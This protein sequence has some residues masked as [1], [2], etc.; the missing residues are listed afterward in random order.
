MRPVAV[1]APTDVIDHAVHRGRPSRIRRGVGLAAA[2]A[3][4][5]LT[6]AGVT[7]GAS[8]IGGLVSAPVRLLSGDESLQDVITQ[9]LIDQ[10]QMQVAFAGYDKVSPPDLL[11]THE[12]AQNA[13][14]T[15]LGA[16]LLQFNYEDLHNVA[17]PFAPYPWD[18]AATNMQ[19]L[20]VYA[21]PDDQYTALPLT[22][23]NTYTMTITPP[24]GPN[25]TSDVTFLEASGNGV[26]QPYGTINSY[27]LDQFTPNANGS[28]TITFA[29]TNPDPG[30]PDFN[31]IE[32]PADAQRT[33]VRD[34][35]GNWGLP[36]DSFS[37]T[38]QGV[39]APSP[40]HPPLLTDSEISQ[41]ILGPVAEHAVSEVGSSDYFGQIYYTNLPEPNTMTPIGPTPKVIPAGPLLN[42]GQQY[43]S[44]GDFKL[45]P[46]EA[47]IL[48][49]PDVEGAY[50]SAMV[51]NI[52][53]QTAPTATATGSLNPGDTFHAPDGYTY[54][55]ISSQ[56][57]TNGTGDIY[58]NWLN[59]NGAADGGI[60]LRFQGITTPPSEPLQVQTYVVPLNDVGTIV[61]TDTPTITPAQYAA[62]AQLRL[63]E[64][65]YVHDQN[66]NTG[67]L[68][69]NLEY[70]QIKAA[71]GPQVFGQIF[72]GQGTQFGAPQEV[73]SVLDR[74]I[75]PALIPNPIT[76][77]ED[78]VKDPTGSVLALKDNLPLALNDIE[79]PT[80][81]SFLRLEVA[82]EQ[83]LGEL[84]SSVSSGQWPQVFTDLLNGVGGLATVVNETLTDP[85]TSITAG[86]LNARDDL[87]V[88][89][90][91]AGS[92]SAPGGA[93]SFSDAVSQLAQSVI[94][95][96]NPAAAFAD[97]N[98]LSAEITA[99]IAAQGA[100][101]APIAA[102][103]PLDLIP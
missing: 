63:F 55:I 92:Y 97:F 79:M 22:P 20:L 102:T 74:M 40:L 80:I 37:I 85:G 54:Y 76:V 100:E 42:D 17:I 73:P 25:G 67:W 58:A 56:A 10:Q 65:D 57:P 27:N 82:I 75:N 6:A 1:T 34:S 52:F 19:Q 47:L 91:N 99:Q 23:G 96:L 70:D 86:F 87:A 4:G 90:F 14:T 30:N 60:W 36:H 49:V 11:M 50:A 98:T 95:D 41:L 26:T 33:V 38:Q 9:L 15:M 28:Y 69:S 16:Q 45:T 18:A 35:V 72:G 66:E 5:A 59:D 88:S 77:I 21:N 78:I 68:G 39:P 71:L 81:L 103:L 8:H 53:G 48:K 101:I 84:K 94:P 29:S 13:L 24:A 43:L 3:I 89:I 7:P 2:A 61:P 12:Y 51:T 44:A 64:W 31:F 32:I 62:D 93:A 46:E 83:T